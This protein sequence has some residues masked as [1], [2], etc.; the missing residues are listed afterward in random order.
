MAG[1]SLAPLE[2]WQAHV[3]GDGF[4]GSCLY[5]GRERLVAWFLDLYPVGSFGN[6]DEQASLSFRSSPFF[7]VNMDVGIERLD[8]N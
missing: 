5:L 2:Q 8:A 4:A 1:P 6:L 3:E 7:T